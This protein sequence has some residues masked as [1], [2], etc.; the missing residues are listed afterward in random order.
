MEC[1]TCLFFYTIRTQVTRLLPAPRRERNDLLLPR[2]NIASTHTHVMCVLLMCAHSYTRPYLLYSLNG[3]STRDSFPF[4]RDSL[5]YP[6]RFFL[7]DILY[8]AGIKYNSLLLP[9]V[10]HKYTYRRFL[11]ILVLKY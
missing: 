7:I 9:H 11:I 10:P 1:D 4:K 5:F 3:Q 2:T 6:S 8:S